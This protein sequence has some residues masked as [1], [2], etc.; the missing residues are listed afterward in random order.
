MKK[1]PMQRIKKSLFYSL[2]FFVLAGFLLSG[3]WLWHLSYD[4]TYGGHVYE[5]LRTWPAKQNETKHLDTMNPETKKGEDEKETEPSPP[6]KSLLLQNIKSEYPNMVFWLQIDNTVVDYPVM[7]TD[8]NEYYMDHLP[9]GSK[10]SLGSIFID[11]RNQLFDRHLILYGHNIRKGDMFGS[12]K[13]YTKQEYWEAHPSFSIY[14]T[15]KEIIL[16]IFS[17]HIVEAND[18]VYS[19]VFSGEEAYLDFIE[20]LQSSSLYDTNI[21]ITG[22]DRIV[23]LS[24]CTSA[25]YSTRLVIHGVWRK[26]ANSP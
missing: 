15:E 22:N 20:N 21:E 5:S 18:D 17:V 13:N 25:D 12:L 1:S 6:E 4:Q 8:N 7:H 23:T 3:I 26:E 11:C 9:D 19:V 14:T 16:D 24:T 2:Y 10:S